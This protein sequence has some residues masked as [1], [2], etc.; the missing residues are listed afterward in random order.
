MKK[1][2]VYITPTD[3]KRKILIKC[4]MA[5]TF[6]PITLTKLLK[7]VEGKSKEITELEIKNYVKVDTR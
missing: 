3:T 6:R 2:T 1:K 7:A 4:I 5:L